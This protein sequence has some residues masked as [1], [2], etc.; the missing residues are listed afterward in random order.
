MSHVVHMP[1]W[2]FVFAL[3]GAAVAGGALYRR[4]IR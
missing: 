2:M 3:M 4:F 1:V